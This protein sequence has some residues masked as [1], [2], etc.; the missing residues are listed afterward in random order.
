MSWKNK[1]IFDSDFPLILNGIANVKRLNPEYTLELSDDADVDQYLKSMLSKWEY[2]K[3]KNK[4]IVEKVDLW[5]LLKIYHEGGIYIDI[6]RYYNVPFKDIIQSDTK[7]ILPTFGDIDFSQDLMISCKHNPIHKRAI[8][9]N[10]KGR[11]LFNPRGV[12][13]LGPPLYMKAVTEV[14]FGKANKRKPGAEVMEDYREQLRA[15]EHFQ[16]YNEQLPND[17]LIFQFDESTFQE[18]N[19]LTKKDFYDSQQ[20]QRWT[21]GLDSNTKL[22]LLILFLALVLYYFFG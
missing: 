9:L 1:D 13:H 20:V 2:F 3:I 6:D 18:G 10:L 15:A 14:V 22:L 12:F 8:E 17:S 19:G 16:T 7:C 11:F 4:K 5:R 21:K